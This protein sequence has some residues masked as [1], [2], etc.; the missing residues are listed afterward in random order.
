MY[1][2]HLRSA[3]KVTSAFSTPP[4]Y[5][6]HQQIKLIPLTL[7]HQLWLAHSECLNRQ[8]SFYKENFLQQSAK[9]IKGGFMFMYIS[10]CLLFFLFSD[11]P[12]FLLFSIFSH[13]VFFSVLTESESFANLLCEDSR[14]TLFHGGT[15]SRGHA[16]LDG[17]HSNWCRGLHAVHDLR[18]SGC[19][20]VCSD[21]T[22]FTG[23]VTYEK[24]CLKTS[25]STDWF[26]CHRDKRRTE[27]RLAW[28]RRIIVQL[29]FRFYVTKNRSR[30]M[31]IIYI[32]I[33]IDGKSGSKECLSLYCCDTETGHS[34]RAYSI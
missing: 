18:T 11:M 6:Q 13:F 26:L 4:V 12:L 17:R 27:S 31:Y 19:N 9:E 3:T 32:Y 24:L 21:V 5:C 34:Y 10:S 30:K 20:S 28:W 1:Y 29:M 23:H 25:A 16:H 15:V 14:S 7:Q 8:A 2:D 22:H 33:Y